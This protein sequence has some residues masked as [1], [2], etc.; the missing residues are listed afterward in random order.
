M[1]SFEIMKNNRQSHT[2]NEEWARGVSDMKVSAAKPD[3]FTD[4][5]PYLARAT[6][7]VPRTC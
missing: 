2:Q 6:V 1:K 5:P 3:Q 7:P 4:K